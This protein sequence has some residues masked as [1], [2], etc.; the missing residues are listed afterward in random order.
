MNTPRYRQT[1]SV[2]GDG[3]V[4]ITGGLDATGT[5]VASAEVYDPVAKQFSDTTGPMSTPRYVQ[6]ASVLADGKVLI[7]GGLDATDTAV[8]SAEVYEPIKTDQSITF[9]K[10][11]DTAVDG[12]P[13]TLGATATSGLT[14]TY[15]STTPAVCT[16][17]ASDADLVSV[18][19]CTINANQSGNA[20]YNP[21]PQATQSFDVTKTALPNQT[22]TFN[23]NG[24][25]GGSM[26]D[27]S[28]NVP[29]ALTANAFTRT[30]YTFNEWTTQEDGSG[31]SYADGATY[32]FSSSQTLYAQW[33][34][35]SPPPPPSDTELKVIA[36][37]GGKTLKVGKRTKVV[38][39]VFTN[40]KIKKVKTS[41]YLKSDKLK[42][43]SKKRSCKV[44]TKKTSSKANV[45]V[46]PKCS[47]GL[48]IQ[49]EIV[50]KAPGAKKAKWQHTWQ[51]KNKPKT[52]CSLPGNG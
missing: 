1:A 32:L 14:V 43:K 21:A 33:T 19:T 40:G 29:T 15:T 7:T 4:L 50:A 44:E 37:K 10:P 2:L 42:G 38:E 31:T 16:I 28:E 51:V 12:G 27:Q 11:A 41:C 34:P 47:V 52:I 36:K 6:T 25:D 35:L 46:K 39:E 23:G 49:T 3:K 13:V 8:A 20:T 48:K 18:G 22:V 9:P 17:N 24:A 45:W 26:S 5:I 30:G